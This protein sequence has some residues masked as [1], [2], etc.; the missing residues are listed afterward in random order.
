[1]NPATQISPYYQ[2]VLDWIAVRIEKS[3]GQGHVA[4]YIPALAQVD[5]R[6]FGMAIYTCDG[7]T[8]SVGDAF[9]PFSMQS[10]SKVFTL[11]MALRLVG[12]RL[13]HRIGK[14]P[15]GNRFN[16]LVQLEYE[17]GIPRNPFVN[18]GAHVV[19]DSIISQDGVGKNDILREIRGLSGNNQLKFNRD[20]ARSERETG[21]L[22]AAIANFLKAHRNLQADV[23]AVLDA[24]FHQCSIEISCADLAR[25]GS[26]LA[27]G[28]LSPI[29]G[30][31]IATVRRVKRINAVM[32]TCGLYDAVGNF[33]F[34]VGIPAKSGVGGGILAVIPGELCVAVWSPALDKT[35]SSLVGVK[36]LE[37]FTGKIGKS[38]F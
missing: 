21:H 30:E 19:T 31:R 38:V 27:N 7:H 26:F 18:A 1:M 2:T 17:H 35:G 8:A 23:D 29:T 6:K 20:V 12:N 32:M 3:I 36:A 13:W 11:N 14:E 5:S 15:S 37:L 24:Y 34:R 22:N 10:I 16:S 33:A 28:G 25:A 4:T 9:E